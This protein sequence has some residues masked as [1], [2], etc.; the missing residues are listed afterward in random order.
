MDRIWAPWRIQ[1]IHE[2]R[3]NPNCGCVFCE[4]AAPG[5]EREKL[6]LYRGEHSFIVMN[7]YPYNCGHLLIIPN[8]HTADLSILS[9]DEHAEL[10]SLCSKSM[11]VLTERVEAAGFNCGFN[12]GRLAG[13]GILDHLHLHVVPRWA[14]DSNFFPV[15]GDMRSMPEYLHSTYDRLLDGFNEGGAK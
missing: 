1:F 7:R 10:M 14:G 5:D 2:H 13:A 9:K 4:I 12:F 8:R 15:I 11:A 6:V 3:R